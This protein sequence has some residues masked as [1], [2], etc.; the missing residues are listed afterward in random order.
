ML[1]VRREQAPRLP[2]P[3]VTHGSKGG[4]L[5]GLPP[6]TVRRPTSEGL[7]A[8]ARDHARMGFSY[9]AVGSS[10]ER[11]APPGFAVDV[12]AVAVG[13]GSAAFARARAAV[14]R[15]A[16]FDL[17]WVWLPNRAP[18]EPGR[19]VVFASRQFGMWAVNA[20]RIV[21]V[22]D[23]AYRAGFAYG[24]LEDHGVSGE[25]RFLVSRDPSSEEVSFEIYK[26]SRM[27]SPVVAL[28]R[29]FVRDLQLR[30]SR[31]AAEAV[32]VATEVG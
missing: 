5:L 8:F 22:V 2:G 21:Y 32:R 7:E 18:P 23:E 4:D 10:S 29:P 20:C 25:E 19:E 30:F 26:F 24:T 6:L 9:D 3:F 27:A 14:W 28:V 12:H 13:S 1:E 16:M 31:E 11:A 17:P 15:W